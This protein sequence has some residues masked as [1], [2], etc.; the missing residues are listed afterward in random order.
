MC[1]STFKP[2]LK[3]SLLCKSPN[4][5]V[6][7]KTVVVVV[8]VVAET[9][10]VK[11]SIVVI[12]SVVVKE[13]IVVTESI[14]VEKSVVVSKSIVVK[15]AIVVVSVNWI[16]RKNNMYTITTTWYAKGKAKYIVSYSVS[17]KKTQKVTKRNYWN[18]NNLK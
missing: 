4:V 17:E 15:E 12:E 3:Y 11:E 2:S 1:F 8:V 14:V 16:D 7:E 18:F 10:V 9:I 6:I 13:S 5:G